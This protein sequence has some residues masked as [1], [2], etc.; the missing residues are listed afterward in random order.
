MTEYKR[1]WW[2]CQSQHQADRRATAAAVI[3]I[4]TVGM[5]LGIVSAIR[6]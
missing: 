6:W 5:I 2:E 3:V 1:K 4:V